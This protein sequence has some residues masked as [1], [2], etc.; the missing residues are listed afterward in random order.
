[1]SETK[2]K[3]LLN[4]TFYR[5]YRRLRFLRYKRKLLRRQKKIQ[6]AEPP[7]ILKQNIPVRTKSGMS[8]WR[9]LYRSYRILRFMNYRRRLSR[10]KKRLKA[11]GQRLEERE[12]R[13][14]MRRQML[15]LQRQEN[16]KH[17]TEP[18]LKVSGKRKRQSLGRR[19]YRTYRIIRFLR[20][21]RHSK[22]AER[23]AKLK[24][25]R[26][27]AAMERREIR[28]RLYEKRL[29]DLNLER[30]KHQT[31]KRE[32]KEMVRNR[33]R[34]IRQLLKSRLKSLVFELKTFD[35]YTLKRLTSGVLA[36]AENKDKRNNFFI[37]TMNSLVMFILSYMVIYVIGQALT[38]IASLSFNYKV[39]LFYYKI[40]YNIN[41]Y[42]WTAD[43]VKIIY[44]MKPGTGLIAGIIFLILYS[45][46]RDTVG[47]SKLFFLWGF[48]HGMVMF[49]GSLLMGTMLNKD[50]GWVV[51]YMYYRDTGKMIFAL[52]SLF[53]MIT[54][55]SFV[56]KSFLFSGNTYFN[57][58]NRKENKF[59]LASQVIWPAIIGTFL[60]IVFSTPNETY[61]MPDDEFVYK[62]LRLSTLAVM[63]VPMMIY[64]MTMNEI[65]FDEAPR[66]I[67][68]DWKYLIITI[69]IV[70][71]YR[72]GLT[73]GIHF[74]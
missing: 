10:M 18:Q 2:R 67:R 45:I 13:L 70:L 47:N 46:N 26:L 60:L 23:Q 34:L 32:R 19:L 35:K 14:Q 50:F 36:F 28:E 7:A 21:R 57:F 53:S 69:A 25:E 62:I 15:N 42:Q 51:A 38:I 30:K 9:K 49:F 41:S 44:S 73:G 58:I 71:A 22:K 27:S 3:R 24:W 66:K 39:I 16:R 48:L 68:L 64:F 29:I 1:M 4:N 37:I 33:K 65:Y 63:L 54:I 52:I 6:K 11:R 40:Y 61:F 59:L 72:F 31:E 17:V 8:F 5:I 74:G 20:H 56:A 55:G 12:Y 43:A